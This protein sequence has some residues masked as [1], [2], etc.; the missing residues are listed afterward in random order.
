MAIYL[1]NNSKTHLWKTK[2]KGITMS[3][4][5]HKPNPPVKVQITKPVPD[6]FVKNC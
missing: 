1:I 3:I 2:G 6:S 5:L 4:L